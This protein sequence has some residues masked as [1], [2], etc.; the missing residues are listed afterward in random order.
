MEH[1]HS[2]RD[3]LAER[4][5]THDGYFGTRAEAEAELDAI[6]AGACGP[7]ANAMVA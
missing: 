6:L 7:A 3:R 5:K 2:R 4:I 1:G